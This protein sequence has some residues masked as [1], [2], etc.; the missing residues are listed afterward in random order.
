LKLLFSPKKG[1]I[2]KPLLLFI[3]V[4]LSCAATAQMQATPVSTMNHSEHKFINT[5]DLK[6][7]DGPP[8][9]PAGA[10]FTVLD[11]DPSKEGLFTIRAILPANY[12]IPAH[13]HPST[14]NVTVLEGTLYLG[15]GEKLDESKATA[16]TVGGFTALPGKMGHFAFS[17]EGAVIQVYAMG[18]FAITYYN[19]SDDPRTKQ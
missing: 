18:P 4:L 13:W 10:R 17:K 5:K 3:A 16:L 9:L 11:G 7:L 2:M 1:G 14:E 15:M 19:P 8:G 6:W 12:K